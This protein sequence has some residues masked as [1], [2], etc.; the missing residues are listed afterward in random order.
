MHCFAGPAR[1]VADSRRR[2][3][4]LHQAPSR[5]P[6]NPQTMVLARPVDRD[7]RKQPLEPAMQSAR[8]ACVARFWDEGL[9]PVHAVH[10]RSD[11]AR[12]IV[13][14]LWTH[15]AQAGKRQQAG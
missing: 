6:C 4:R 3:L 1:P 5:G 9:Q 14:G 12:P 11:R 10:S 7:A 15:L 13:E 8:S 2:R